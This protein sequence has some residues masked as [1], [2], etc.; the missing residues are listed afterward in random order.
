MSQMKADRPQTF[1]S[2][3]VMASLYR[4]VVFTGDYTVGYAGAGA[5]AIGVNLDTSAAVGRGIL[6]ATQGSGVSVKIEAGAAFAAGSLLAPDATGRAVVAAGG[7]A[8]SAVAFQAA[9]AAG[10]IIEAS[11]EAG[12]A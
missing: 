12:V 7:A 4:F 10:D 8:Y 6:I 9:G 2:N 3:G 1:N 11:L 5:R